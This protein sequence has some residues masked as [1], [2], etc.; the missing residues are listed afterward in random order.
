MAQVKFGTGQLNNPTPSWI[1]LSVRVFTVVAGIFLGWVQ[2]DNT[3]GIPE[4][5][6]AIICSILGLLLAIVNGIAPLFG[7][8]TTQASIPVKEVTAMTT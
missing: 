4:Q 7:V 1:N 6:R 2:A 3:F 5:T 8:N